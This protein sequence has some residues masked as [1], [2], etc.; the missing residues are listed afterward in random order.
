MVP[1]VSIGVASYKVDATTLDSLLKAADTA[2][3]AAK[4][5][6]G[7]TFRCF[8]VE[9]QQRVEDKRRIQTLLLTAV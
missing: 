8:Q 9:M 3:Y 4:E 6:G 2:L 1:S 5:Q 7:N